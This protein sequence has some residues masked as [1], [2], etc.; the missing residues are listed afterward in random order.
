MVHARRTP[1]PK[2]VAAPD[3]RR[4]KALGLSGTLDRCKQV[5]DRRMQNFGVRSGS[6]ARGERGCYEHRLEYQWR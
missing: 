1:G 2:G 5:R 3:S 4:L 6:Q